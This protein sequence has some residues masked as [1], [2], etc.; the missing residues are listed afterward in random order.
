MGYHLTTIIEQHIGYEA[1]LATNESAANQGITE[2]HDESLP[3]RAA[4]RG[5]KRY[6]RS[7]PK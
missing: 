7:L 6:A 1:L 4:P 2:F 5:P 3:Q